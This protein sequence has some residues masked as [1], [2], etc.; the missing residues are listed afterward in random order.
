MASPSEAQVYVDKPSLSD[1]GEA[2]GS[3]SY[4]L[5][6]Q[7]PGLLVSCSVCSQTGIGKES[8]EELVTRGKAK[9]LE[10]AGL[11]TI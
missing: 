1:S 7:S 2:L 9:L 10:V 4:C 11:N 8:R 5:T 6:C 3:N